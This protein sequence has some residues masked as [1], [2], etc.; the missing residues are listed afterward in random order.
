MMIDYPYCL[1]RP[2]LLTPFPSHTHV[3]IRACTH[4]PHRSEFL[5]QAH[6]L[7][8][9]HVYTMGDRGYAREM[10]RLLDPSGRLFNER[11]VSQVSRDAQAR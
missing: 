5:E 3:H 11:V 2:L 8:E 1:L 9:L 6:E 7:A 4:T 10:A